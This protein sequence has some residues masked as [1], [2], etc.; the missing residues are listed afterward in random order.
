MS[1]VFLLHFLHQKCKITY[2]LATTIINLQSSQN[3]R[4]TIYFKVN[5]YYLISYL[6]TDYYLILMK[7]PISLVIIYLT[8]V[9]YLIISIILFYFN[10][11]YI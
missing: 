8:F 5:H 3:F 2:H 11:P 9:I 4:L 10:F 6:T 7:F 1:F